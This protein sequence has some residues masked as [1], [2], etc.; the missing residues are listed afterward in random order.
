MQ[1][2]NKGVSLHHERQTNNPLDKINAMKTYTEIKSIVDAQDE[3]MMLSKP[4]SL[5]EAEWSFY[6]EMD[7]LE[8]YKQSLQNQLIDADNKIETLNAQNGIF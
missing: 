8:R 4:V 6:L 5:T 3:L 7:K 2:Q 1:I